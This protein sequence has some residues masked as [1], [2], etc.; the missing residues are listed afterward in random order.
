MQLQ[1][2]HDDRAA[3]IALLRR[4]AELGIDHIDTAQFYGNGFVNNLIR[5]AIRPKDGALVAS[6]VGATPDPDGP[7][8]MRPA[9]RRSCS[10]PN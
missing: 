2:L 1:R 10:T 8:P 9:Q 4:V 5:E 3:G 6:K 7:Y